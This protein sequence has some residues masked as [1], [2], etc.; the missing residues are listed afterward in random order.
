[1]KN[2]RE[3]LRLNIVAIDAWRDAD[4]WTWNRWDTIRQGWLWA[5]DELTPRKI[6]RRLRDDGIASPYST[7]QLRVEVCADDG[8]DGTLIEIQ[9]RNTGEPLLALTNLHGEV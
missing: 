6:L 1:V 7:G 4:G 9:D 5:D 8:P 3:W 2:K